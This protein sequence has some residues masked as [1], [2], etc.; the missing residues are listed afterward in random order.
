MWLI[1]SRAH[2]KVLLPWQNFVFL[3]PACLGEPPHR[4]DRQ[5]VSILLLLQRIELG[6]TTNEPPHDKTNKMTCVPS[7][8]SDQPWHPPNLIRVCAVHMKKPWVL[9]YQMNTQRRLWSVQVDAQTDLSLRW[10]QKSFYWFCHEA[11]Q[12]I[13]PFFARQ[14]S[15]MH[16]FVFLPYI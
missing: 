15:F 3:N 1:S 6:L 11:A 13:I 2:Q 8:D 9:I 4:T 7:K 5:Q 10:V 16:W 12:V 14:C